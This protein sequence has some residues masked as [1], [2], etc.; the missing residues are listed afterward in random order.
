MGSPSEE[1]EWAWEVSPEEAGS[2]R[3]LGL[4]G[5]VQTRPPSL[6]YI[7]PPETYIPGLMSSRIGHDAW[8]VHTRCLT[9]LPDYYG[10]IQ[11]S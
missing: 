10:F 6:A 1:D 8:V 3:I 4:G 2:L 7:P 9:S 5:R 11:H